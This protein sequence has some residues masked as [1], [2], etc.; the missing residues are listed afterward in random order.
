MRQES[1][2]FG[3]DVGKRR[4]GSRRLEAKG[5][6]KEGKSGTEFDF[7]FDF[8]LIDAPTEAWSASKKRG[9]NGQKGDRCSMVQPRFGFE[10]ICL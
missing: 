3:S 5:R 9:R 7:L 2:S 6:E 1:L 10:Q 4:S 8:E